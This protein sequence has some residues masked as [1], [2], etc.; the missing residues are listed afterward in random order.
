MVD[1]FSFKKKYTPA[2]MKLNPVINLTCYI[3]YQMFI[4]Y[5]QI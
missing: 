3:T 2:E 5:F 4:F 1:N